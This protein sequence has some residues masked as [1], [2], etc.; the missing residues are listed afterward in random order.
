MKYSTDITNLPGNLGMSVFTNFFRRTAI[1]PLNM[2]LRI[3]TIKT[4]QIHRIASDMISIISPITQSFQTPA[5]FMNMNSPVPENKR[6][7]YY[8]TNCGMGS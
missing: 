2:L 8:M 6:K 1:G 7:K 4:R 3:L 5:T